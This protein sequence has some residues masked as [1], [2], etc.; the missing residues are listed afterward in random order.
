MQASITILITQINV[1]FTHSLCSERALSVS[2]KG[3][4]ELTLPQNTVELNAAVNPDDTSGTVW[5]SAFLN[6]N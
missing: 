2:I 1:S 4:V 6:R 3:P 5:P